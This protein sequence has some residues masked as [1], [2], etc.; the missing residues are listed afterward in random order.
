MSGVASYYNEGWN[1]NI[2]GVRTA[3]GRDFNA[4]EF[5]AAHN[6][7]KM[8]SIVDV[9]N[10]KNNKTVRVTIT[11]RGGFAKYNRVIDLSKAA[12]MSICDTSAGL[13]KVNIRLIKKGSWRYSK[14]LISDSIKTIKD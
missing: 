5:T 7:F 1:T 14:G 3:S 8:G 9:T 6:S 13:C 10:I 12:F 11:D 4:K 2:T